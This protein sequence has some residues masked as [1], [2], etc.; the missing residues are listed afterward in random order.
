MIRL[1]NDLLDLD[2]IE[3]GRFELRRKALLVEDAITQAITA[4]RP[5]AE[6]RRV[7][8]EGC[9]SSAEVYVDSDRIVQALTNVLSL[10]V[11]VSSAGS[12]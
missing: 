1:I 4:V 11:G 9:D 8:V 2:K 5:I 6:E 12:R 7:T 10:V 3:A